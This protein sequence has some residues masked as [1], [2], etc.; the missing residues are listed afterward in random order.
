MS[1]KVRARI[2]WVTAENGGR[3]TPPSGARYST[4]ARFDAIKDRWP[5]EAWSIVANLPEATEQWTMEVE[6]RM[7]VDSA[8]EHLLDAGSSFDLFEGR[9]LVGQGVVL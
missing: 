8:P 4:A 6:L 7:L 5:A 9:T 1:K 2:T 3:P